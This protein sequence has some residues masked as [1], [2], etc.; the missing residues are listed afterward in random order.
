MGKEFL[1]RRGDPLIL[2]LIIGII[3]KEVNF[4]NLTDGG[5]ITI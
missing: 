5:G 4:L 3:I 2:F 1:R